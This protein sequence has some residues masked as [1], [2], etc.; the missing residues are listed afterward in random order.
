MARKPY[1]KE[2]IFEVLKWKHDNKKTQLECAAEFKLNRKTVSNWC[3]DYN[4]E[5]MKS[6]FNFS[7]QQNSNKITVEKKLPDG[8]KDQANANLSR[9][10]GIT[11]TSLILLQK[12]VE[13]KLWYIEKYG[14][15]KLKPFE[16]DKLN[17][18]IRDA[19]QY[20]IPSATDIEDEGISLVESVRNKLAQSRME[21]EERRNKAI[22][23]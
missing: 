13:H 17:R 23:S 18:I 1:P 20:T 22:N 4:Y 14:I 16:V 10:S 15:E 6:E 8:I 9:L 21:L 7:Y 11:S 2:K 12:W 5:E 3:R 19:S